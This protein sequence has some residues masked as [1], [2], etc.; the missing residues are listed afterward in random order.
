[1]NKYKKLLGN[2][3]IFAIGTFGIKIINVIL[4]PLYTHYLST[5]EYGAID[6]VTTTINMILPIISLSIYDAVLRFTMDNKESNDN[7]LSNGLAVIILGSIISLGLYPLFKRFDA[8]EGLIDYLYIILICQ[9]LNSL[10]SQFTRG[11]GEVKIFTISG[12]IKTLILCICNIGFLVFLDLGISGYFI[13]VI[14]S[15]ITSILFIL[16]SVKIHQ[17]I[18]FDNLNLNLL[19]RMMS[20]SIPLIPNSFMWWLINASNRYFILYYEGVIINGLFAVAN[21]IPVLLTLFTS[22]FY[23]AWQLS[24]IEEYNSENKSKFFSE[25]FYYYQAVLFLFS[26]ATFVIL[27]VL[28]R[29]IFPIEYHSSWKYVPFLLLGALFSSFSSFLGTNYIAA[30]DTKGVFKTSLI[31]GI[32]SLLLNILLVPFIGAIGAGIST[33]FSFFIIWIV[34]IVDTKR[35]IS[36]KINKKS[37]LI[38]IIIISLQIIILFLKFNIILEL[39]FEASLFILHLFLYR[40]ILYKFIKLGMN[41]LFSRK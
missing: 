31:G 14:I 18:R 28:I 22:I 23:Q 41:K 11:I 29:F 4:V 17:Y 2:S 40:K 21:K 36:M 8:I 25:V 15:E 7:V 33:M 35:Y 27:K 6:I 12:I 37:S 19:K 24:A 3:I 10:L 26:S 38:S 39:C 1:M 5:S 20:Y 34:R 9:S 16:F 30:K 32:I 13:S